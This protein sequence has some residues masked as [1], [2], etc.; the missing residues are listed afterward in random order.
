MTYANLFSH[1]SG[2]PDHAGDLLEDLGFDRDAILDQLGKL[3]LNPIDRYVYTNF[4]LTVAAVRAAELAGETWEDFA[5]RLLY[6]KLDMHSTNSRFETFRARENRTWGH[7]RGEDGR[8]FTATQRNPD[9]QSPAGGVT[10]SAH[11]LIAWVK[12]QLGD[13]EMLRK[14]GLEDFGSIEQ[15]H[16]RF[17]DRDSYGYGW[18]VQSDDKGRVNMLSHSGAFDM[19]AGTSVALWPQEKLGIVALTNAKPTGGAEALSPKRCAPDS[20]SCSTMIN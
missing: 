8:F 9:A 13:P 2:L 17:I 14:V 18:N 16:C 20:G 1:R 5:D 10:S 19:G 15:T 7:R 4:G 12:L 11:D 6:R 3:A